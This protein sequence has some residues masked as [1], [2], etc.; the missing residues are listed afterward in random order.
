MAGT[1]AATGVRRLASGR[2]SISHPDISGIK[3]GPPYP[4]FAVPLRAGVLNASVLSQSG[5]GA[6]LGQAFAGSWSG[7]W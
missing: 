6:F 4:P 2:V 5:K 1:R 7:K 3:V